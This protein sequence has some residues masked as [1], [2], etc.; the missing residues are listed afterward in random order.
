MGA[1]RQNHQLMLPFT[2]VEAGEARGN[3]RQGAESSKASCETERP[4]SSIQAVMEVICSPENMTAALRRVRTNK[5]AAGVDGMTVHELQSLNRNVSGQDLCWGLRDYALQRW[6]SLAG[7]VLRRWQLS[8]T[9]DFGAIV[10]A[11]VEHGFMQTESHDTIEDF[12][13]VFSFA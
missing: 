8:R 9:E 1:T 11:M 13:S 10:F 4:V 12:S 5:G 3:R 2:E 7:L 6:G